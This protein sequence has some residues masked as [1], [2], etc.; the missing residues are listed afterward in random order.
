MRFTK[1]HGLGNDYIYVN[2]ISQPVKDLSGLAAAMS[3]RHFGVGADGLIALRAGSSGDF[4]ME[5]YNADGSRGEMCGNGIRCLGKYIYDNGLTTKTELIIDTPAGQRPLTLHLGPGGVD[6]I[7]TDMGKVFLFPEIKLSVK[8]KSFSGIPVS[9]GNPH[10]VIFTQDLSS[11]LLD[12]VGPAIEHH[13]LF[14]NRTNVEF[15]QC[16][17]DRLLI[18]VWERGS[19]ETLACGTGACAC[20]AAAV[21]LGLCGH[22]ATAQLPGGCLSLRYD[23]TSEHIY[24]T[25]PAVTVFDGEWP[26]G[27]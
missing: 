26:D 8:G 22:Q 25:G 10:F 3:D 21:H 2:L 16:A 14:P 23:D 13:P 15:V 6:E 7:T 12:V 18:R 19:G 5:M 4:T 20:F 1:M 27:Q 9:T 11:V 17:G 24:M